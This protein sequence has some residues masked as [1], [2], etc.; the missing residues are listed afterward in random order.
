MPERCFCFQ[1]GSRGEPVDGTAVSTVRALLQGG[2][3]SV[4]DFEAGPCAQHHV[5]AAS[6]SGWLGGVVVGFLLEDR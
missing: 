3:V 4:G 6:W 5:E 1:T 2:F